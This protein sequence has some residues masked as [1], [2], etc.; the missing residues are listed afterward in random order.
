MVQKSKRIYYLDRIKFLLCLL[1]IGQHTSIVYGG[2][3]TWFYIEE[4]HNIAVNVLFTIYNTVCQSFFMGLFF[5]ISAYFTVPS[6]NKKGCKK[7]LK[8]RAVRLF[9]PLSIFYFILHPTTVFFVEKMYKN[10]PVSYFD[11]MYNSIV[12]I[13][14]VGFG[15]LWFVEALIIFSVGYVLYRK[16]IRKDTSKKVFMAYENG[17]GE[18]NGIINFPGKKAILRFMIILGVTTFIVRIVFP[19]GEEILNMKFGYFPQYI[20]LFVLGT[21]AYENKWLDQITE[22]TSSFYFK[23]SLACF[24]LLIGILGLFM[25]FGS[26][27]VGVFMGGMSFQALIYALWEPFMCV[28][29]SLKLITFFRKKYNMPSKMWNGLSLD[30]YPV[31]VI[32]APVSVF[33]ECLL[34]GST[35]NPVVKCFTVY[36][37]TCILCF[38]ASHFMIRKVPLLRRIF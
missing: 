4:V 27:D 13:D 17:Q 11:Y 33:L 12:N 10:N 31:F 37:A 14:N 25:I 23:I 28:G 20:A 9:I 26:S 1:V 2:S 18:T 38:G 32:H 29:I 24:V 36:I 15:P 6:Y 22:K 16:I 5:F 19:A 35:L 3:G 7:F 8:D 30:T 34:I 21:I